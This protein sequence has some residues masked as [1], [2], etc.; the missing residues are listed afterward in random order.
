MLHV[1]IKGSAKLNSPIYAKP[2]SMEALKIAP[3][4]TRA[5]LMTLSLYWRLKFIIVGL[6]FKSL[7]LNSAIF[8]VY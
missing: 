6:F 4:N 2:C 3:T 1:L 8:Y 5:K 7:N